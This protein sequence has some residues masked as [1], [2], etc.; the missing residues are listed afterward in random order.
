MKS[1]LRS[2]IPGAVATVSLLVAGSLAVAFAQ[3]SNAPA[4]GDRV[5]AEPPRVDVVTWAPA[6]QAPAAQIVVCGN[7]NAQLAAP[8]AVAV[9]QVIGRPAVPPQFYGQ[10][11]AGFADCA[12][13]YSSRYAVPPQPG[14]YVDRGDFYAA[15][16]ERAMRSAGC[17]HPR[18][19]GGRCRY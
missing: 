1:L 10:T 13:V 15:R 2:L 12:P 14:T 17:G 7:C 11:A 6:P 19:C 5:A 4:R 18:E 3:Q 9:A 8:Q 16:Y